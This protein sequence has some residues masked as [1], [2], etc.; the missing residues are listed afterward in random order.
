MSEQEEDLRDME[1]TAALIVAGKLATKHG[2]T[3]DSQSL[4][5]FLGEF[6][7]TPG[8]IGALATTLAAV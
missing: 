5:T 1:L 3:G 2:V 6:G 4:I 8:D 7:V